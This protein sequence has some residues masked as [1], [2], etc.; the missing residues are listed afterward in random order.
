MNKPELLRAMPELRLNG[1]SHLLQT[2]QGIGIPAFASNIV[3]A[4]EIYKIPS[5]I[6]KHMSKWLSRE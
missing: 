6:K 1:K 5:I 2:N 3:K 4:S